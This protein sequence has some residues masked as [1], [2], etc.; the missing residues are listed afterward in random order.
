MKL[1]YTIE[2]TAIVLDDDGNYVFLAQAQIDDDGTGPAHGDPDEQPSTS[3][4]PYLNAD[5]DRYIVLPP[6]MLLAVA[7]MVIGCRA[8]VLNTITGLSTEA[9]VGDIGPRLKIGEM[10]IATAAAIGVPSSPTTGGVDEH[11]IFYKVYPGVPAKVGNKT[12]V[13]Q[14]YSV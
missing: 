11:I 10:S 12:Y 13:L 1:L 4:R 14:H 6:Q 8:Q 9:V 5:V 7:P 3:Y 2:N